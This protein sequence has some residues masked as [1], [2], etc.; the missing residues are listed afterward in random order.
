M[1]RDRRRPDTE[2]IRRDIERIS[3]FIQPGE[4]GFTRLSFSEEDRRAREYLAGL[5]EKEAGLTVRIDAAGNLVGTRKG[6]K[7]KPFLVRGPTSIRFEEEDGL[8]G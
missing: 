8:T 2:R 3:E 6:K 4:P 1:Q 5:M 7:E